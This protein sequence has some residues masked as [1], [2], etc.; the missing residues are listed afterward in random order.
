MFMI[1]ICMM[2]GMILWCFIGL[3]W[4]ATWGILKIVGV[5]LSIIAF[6]IL[7]IGLLVVG[8]GSYLLLPVF[9]LAL[10]FGCIAKA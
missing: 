2:I 3:A 5:L 7:L 8:I 4:K 10:A 1:G 9:L 6:P